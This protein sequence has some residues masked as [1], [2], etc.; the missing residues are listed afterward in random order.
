MDDIIGGR[1]YVKSRMKEDEFLR[2]NAIIE[3]LYFLD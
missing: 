1:L 3:H 2:E